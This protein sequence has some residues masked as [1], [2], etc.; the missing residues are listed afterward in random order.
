MQEKLMKAIQ[1]KEKDGKMGDVE[2]EAK[3]SVVSHLM[4]LAEEAMNDNLGKGLKQGMKVSVMGDSKHALKEGL[5]EAKDILKNVPMEDKA[6]IVG[7]DSEAEGD[8][9]EGEEEGSPAEEAA[10][11]SD[12]E[13]AEL[14]KKIAELKSKK[15]A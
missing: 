9:V 5:D 10:E 8:E 4:Q 12:E 7:E 14:E 3:K 13:I 1:K 11:G 6:K 15:K 2:K